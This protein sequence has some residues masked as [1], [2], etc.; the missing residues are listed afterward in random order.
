MNAIQPAVSEI[1]APLHQAFDLQRQAYLAAPV[2]NYSE[3]KQDLQRL[4]YSVIKHGRYATRLHTTRTGERP[5]CE[6]AYIHTY[7]HTCC[8][9]T[10][11]TWC[12]DIM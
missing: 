3:R 4:D 11:A 10:A 6:H 5:G 12:Y 8:L 7:I 2:P 9:V 1:A